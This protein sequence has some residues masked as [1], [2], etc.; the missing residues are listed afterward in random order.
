MFLVQM[1]EGNLIR[2][3]ALIRAFLCRHLDGLEEAEIALP[4]VSSVWRLRRSFGGIG[5]GRRDVFFD[6][7]G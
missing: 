5:V 4:A 2:M 3:T 6:G 1:I 7:G